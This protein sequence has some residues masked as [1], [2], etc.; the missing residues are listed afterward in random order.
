MAKF[1]AAGRFI[2]INEKEE[3]LV[4]KHKKNWAIP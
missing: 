3:I 2:I 4:V 1:R